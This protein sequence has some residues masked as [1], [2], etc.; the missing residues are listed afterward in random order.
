M[1]GLGI[2]SSSK[3][4]PEG[5]HGK[6]GHGRLGADFTLTP[7]A[8][9]MYGSISFQSDIAQLVFTLPAH[10]HL[11]TPIEV[12]RQNLATAKTDCHLALEWI[13]EKNS[14]DMQLHQDI[15]TLHTALAPESKEFA[16]RSLAIHRRL[17]SAQ[18]AERTQRFCQAWDAY[19][20]VPTDQSEWRRQ[21]SIALAVAKTYPTELIE[22]WTRT[23]CR[24]LAQFAA[25]RDAT[26]GLPRVPPLAALHQRQDL[27]TLSDPQQETM[28][29]LLLARPS[30]QMAQ[31]AQVLA[32]LPINTLRRYLDAM[33]A[34]HQHP[35]SIQLGDY[36]QKVY[37]PDAWA[38]ALK[39]TLQQG[40]GAF[41]EAL[42][43]HV[44]HAVNG[45]LSQIER[46][47]RD[48]L[49]AVQNGTNMGDRWNIPCRRAL[50]AREEHGQRQAKAWT[51]ALRQSVYSERPSSPTDG[52][53]ERREALQSWGIDQLVRWI[54]GPVT[55]PRT[56]AA[57]AKVGQQ[58][59]PAPRTV[60]DIGDTDDTQANASDMPQLLPMALSDCARFLLGE[61]QDL[62]TLAGHLN[63]QDAIDPWLAASAPGLQAIADAKSDEDRDPE[64]EQALLTRVDEALTGLRARLT[65][66]KSQAQLSTRFE[67][68]LA[69]ALK[70]EDLM[71]GKRLGG[72][73]G[74]P[75]PA[76]QWAAVH[77]RYHQRLLPMRNTLAMGDSNL[78]LGSDQALALYVTG[79][80]QSG[81]AFD[82]SVH[83]WARRAGKTSPPSLDH[84]PYPRMN[85]VNWFDTYQP[86]CVL[87]VP[88][89]R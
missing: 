79:S 13:G 15:C 21:K 75:L 30:R 46:L 32:P 69:R 37:L 64:A 19:S 3:H 2:H 81:Y 20:L 4:Q 73:I 56:R 63:Q 48:T 5:M 40:G 8:L 66:V 17:P 72:V 61:W 59:K 52:D 54:D 77:E 27:S 67:A 86:C 1:G 33:H 11:S 22:A 28:A 16:V 31:I 25:A 76:E 84:A 85:T 7:K 51:M 18:Q 55:A 82:I 62:R 9:L 57:V 80:S 58:P 68:A 47:L 6:A 45:L 49:D 70:G 87:H 35:A 14:T 12:I 26:T 60:E 10:S 24:W 88:L 23:G 71:L 74:C 34:T 44:S 42:A 53:T 43:L 38:E 65:E 78:A 89:A 36:L 41:D 50:S 39:D 29:N 83:L